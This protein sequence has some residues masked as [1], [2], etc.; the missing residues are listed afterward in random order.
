MRKAADYPLY[1]DY[2]GY[3]QPGYNPGLDDP[4]VLEHK[5]YQEPK[6]PDQWPEWAMPTAMIA[7]GLLG[8]G[9]LKHVGGKGIQRLKQVAARIG[10]DA[11][12]LPPKVKMGHILQQLKHIAD[13]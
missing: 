1:Q 4:R 7:S 10:Q 13:E 11:P 5:Y 8:Y 12:L 6:V 9:L 3:G 2:S